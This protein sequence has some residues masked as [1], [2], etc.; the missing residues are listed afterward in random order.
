MHGSDNLRGWGQAPSPDAQLLYVR[1][2]DAATQRYR[3][4]VN[5]RFGATRPQ[6]LTL[7]QPVVL[8]TSM[9]FDLGPTRERQNVEQNIGRGRDRPGSRQ[10]QT[11][12][13]NN[14]PNSIPNPLSTILRQQDTLRLTS[15]QADSIAVLNRRYTYRADSIWAPVARELGALGQTYDMDAVYDLYI[16]ARRAQVDMLLRIAANVTALLTPEQRRKLPM[17]VVNAL[18]PRYLLSIR[19]GTNT[20]VSGGGRFGDFGRFEQ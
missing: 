7:R 20:F 17:Q 19:N 2:F 12:W 11:Y 18:D 1:G 8:T 5:Q 15:Q 4:E 14:G 9:R 16:Q 6:F 10:S 13:R 3:Y